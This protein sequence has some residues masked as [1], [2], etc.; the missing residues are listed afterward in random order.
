MGCHKRLDFVLFYV[1][2]YS[3]AHAHLQAHWLLTNFSFKMPIKSWPISCQWEKD[4]TT[5]RS[6]LLRPHCSCCGQGSFLLSLSQY[7]EDEFQRGVRTGTVFRGC[8]EGRATVNHIRHLRGAKITEIHR[9]AWLMASLL[10]IGTFS[11]RWMG[12]EIDGRDRES[13]SI[14]WFRHQ[15]FLIVFSPASADVSVLITWYC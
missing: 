2:W 1:P 11:L 6:K 13:G 12:W 8:T 3:H 14:H 5:K 7:V 9:I 4:N 15:C 10:D